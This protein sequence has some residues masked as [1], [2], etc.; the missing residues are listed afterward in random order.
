M[1]RLPT[2]VDDPVLV[3]VTVR[4]TGTLEGVRTPK[5][6]SEGARTNC[7]A[8]RVIEGRFTVCTAAFAAWAVIVPGPEPLRTMLQSAPAP[9]CVGQLC[10]REKPVALNCRFVAVIE[11]RFRSVM[12]GAASVESARAAPGVRFSFV[13]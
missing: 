4:V 9:S 5:L 6:I 8:D 12:F 13:R 11:P 7:A 3:M 1:E 2:C 10:V